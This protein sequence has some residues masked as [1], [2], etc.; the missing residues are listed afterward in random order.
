MSVTKITAKNF[1]KLEDFSFSP[2]GKSIFV[3]GDSGEGKSTLLRIILSSLMLEDFPA[4]PLT[5]GKKSGFV[6]TEH[7]VDGMKYTVK[8]SFTDDRTKKTRFTVVD[9]NGGKYSLSEVL[10][11]IYGKAFTSSNFDYYQFFF[12]N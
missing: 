7:D 4:D 11:K 1:K 6:E 3:V 10:E 8:R 9:Q 12:A 2:N 5:T